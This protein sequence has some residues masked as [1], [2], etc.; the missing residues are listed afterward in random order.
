MIQVV[1]STKA[2]TSILVSS[3]D[4]NKVRNILIRYTNH[5]NLLTQGKGI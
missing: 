5:N 4:W 2:V 1:V 3:S